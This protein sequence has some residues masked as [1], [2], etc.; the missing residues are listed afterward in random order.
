[1]FAQLLK[2]FSVLMV[3]ISANVQGKIGFTGR[4]SEPQPI[5]FTTQTAKNIAL[6][7]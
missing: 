5:H 1:M 3:Y 7:S 4:E 2:C 6:I